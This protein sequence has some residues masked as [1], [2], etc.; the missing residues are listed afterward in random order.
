MNREREF[1]SSLLFCVFLGMIAEQCAM[2]A[3][4][5]PTPETTSELAVNCAETFIGLC[6]VWTISIGAPRAIGF[7]IGRTS[8]RKTP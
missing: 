5:R 4:S 1:V 8:R 2:F 7:L 6:I 3:F